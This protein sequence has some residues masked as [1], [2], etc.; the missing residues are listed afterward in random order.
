MR[1]AAALFAQLELDDGQAEIAGVAEGG[2]KMKADTIFPRWPMSRALS[3]AANTQPEVTT[4]M[5][6]HAHRQREADGG[7][8]E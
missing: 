7:G 4:M 2:D 3:M 1:R 5:K 8:A 6:I